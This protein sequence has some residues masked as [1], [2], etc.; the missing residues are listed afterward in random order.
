MSK[1]KAAL[2]RQFTQA[3]CHPAFFV[4]VFIVILILMVAKYR[5]AAVQTA[6]ITAASIIGLGILASATFVGVQIVRSRAHRAEAVK[7]TAEVL[8]TPVPES[9]EQAGIEAEANQLAS[10]ALQ[11][12]MSPDGE[13][14]TIRAHVG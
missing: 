13:I 6:E 4:G 10:P 12:A 14:T 8:A 7:A 9:A 3:N 1:V 5:A 2:Y 11:L